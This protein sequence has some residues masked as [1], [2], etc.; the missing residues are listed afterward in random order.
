MASGYLHIR[1]LSPACDVVQVAAA[2]VEAMS[3]SQGFGIVEVG[4]DP[5][6]P[7]EP[8]ADQMAQVGGGAAG[9]G[10]HRV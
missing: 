1:C 6:A 4:A 3:A 8:L 2:V 10:R 5:E 9:T 7:K